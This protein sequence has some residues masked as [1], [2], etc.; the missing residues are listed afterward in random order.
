MKRYFIINN[1]NEQIKLKDI[2]V[3]LFEISFS[4]VKNIIRIC[5]QT[6]LTVE[7]LKLV[8]YILILA[9]IANIMPVTSNNIK[10]RSITIINRLVL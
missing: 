3:K 5:L 4:I 10:I 2:M 9:I 6:F 7:I 1:K 8:N